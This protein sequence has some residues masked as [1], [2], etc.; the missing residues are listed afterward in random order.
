[1]TQSSIESLAEIYYYSEGAAV[2][3]IWACAGGPANRSTVHGVCTMYRCSIYELNER[4]LINY[5]D[6]IIIA[7]SIKI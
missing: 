2:V 4:T 5:V 3:L 7:V 1:M 6:Y